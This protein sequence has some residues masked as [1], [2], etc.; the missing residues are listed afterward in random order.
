MLKIPAFYL[1]LR[2]HDHVWRDRNFSLA[3][4]LAASK[5]LWP[6]E[7]VYDHEVVSCVA[8]GG[9]RLIEVNPK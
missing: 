9:R 5:S 4:R 6:C 3:V 2:A 8:E 7:L 1:L